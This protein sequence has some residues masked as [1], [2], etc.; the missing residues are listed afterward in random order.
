MA[1]IF[2]AIASVGAL[3]GGAL[4]AIWFAGPAL[5]SGPVVPLA[6]ESRA[7]PLSRAD[8]AL[9]RVGRLK[10]LGAIRLESGDTRFGG[11]SGMLWEP[12]CRRL[13]AVSDAGTWFL[14]E[15]REVDGRLEGIAAAWIAP[16]LGPDGRPPISKRAADAEAL[17]RTPD[18]ATWVFYEQSHRGERF[19]GLSGCRPESLG[20]AP[21]RRWVPPGSELWPEN[22][23][24][25]AVA[26]GEAGLLMVLEGVPGEAGG[27]LG[28]AGGPDGPIARFTWAGPTGFQPTA[29]E[30]LEA[31][32]D[33]MLVLHRRFTPLQGVSAILMEGAIGA[34]ASGKVEPKEIARFAAP[35][36]VDNMEAL[37]V[38][39]EGERRFVYLASDDN[40]N[41]L[42]QTL[43]LKFEL[44]SDDAGKPQP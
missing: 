27:M 10:F 34:P 42:Q 7:L 11:I 43:L 30:P 40:F 5:G 15:P 9:D 24:M 19:A 6:V 22:G 23:G 18:G 32:G 4:M 13:L 12:G 29:M 2:E 44:L 16:V 38:R 25:E 41:A 33:T 36:L 20:V 28:L 3:A 31:G 21:D 8:P 37:A 39:R 35:L 1:R 26:S 17:A 14:L